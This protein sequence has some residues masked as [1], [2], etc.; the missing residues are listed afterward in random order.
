MTQ[1][2]FAW[3]KNLYIGAADI[4]SFIYRLPTF[5]FRLPIYN[6]LFTNSFNYSL[7]NSEIIM[8]WQSKIECWPPMD[9]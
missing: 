5:N 7:N 8:Y 2:I 6:N 9:R 1:I 4:L 3:P